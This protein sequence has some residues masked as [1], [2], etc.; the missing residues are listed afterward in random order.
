MDALLATG[1]HGLIKLVMTTHGE[2]TQNEFT[3]NVL[4]WN[5]EAKHP[6]F[7]EP[8]TFMVYQPMLELL[9]FLQE[10]GYK[11]YIVSGGGVD[12]MRPL[13]SQGV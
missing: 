2:L 6:K 13:L 8:F 10:Y 7:K 11:T 5:K 1:E 9:H 3:Q 4:S 12:F